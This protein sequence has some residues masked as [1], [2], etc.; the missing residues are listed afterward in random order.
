MVEDKK[1]EEVKDV[2]VTEETEAPQLAEEVA[3]GALMAVPQ[4][5]VSPNVLL[6]MA[7]TG[8][9]DIDK[10]GKL[11][12]LQERH[13]KNE[14]RKAYVVAMAAFK[15]NPPEIFKDK[16]VSY[17]TGKGTTTYDHA[18]LA[19][20]TGLINKGLSEHGLSAAWK[21]D[22]TEKSITVTCVITHV[23]GHSES[24][25]LTGPPDTSG[26]KN[27]IQAIA[28]TV[29]YLER[30]TILGLT[31]LSTYDM[32]DDGRGGK[33]SP[34]CNFEETEDIKCG[35]ADLGCVMEDEDYDYDEEEKN[36]LEK[37]G[38][39]S[40]SEMTKAQYEKGIKLIA[41]KK[42]FLEKK[43]ESK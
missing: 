7:L 40:V 2:A 25:S 28:S 42:E 33:D 22:Q 41:A 9:A 19:N 17:D 24:T 35:L 21:H 29:S 16:T 1:E 4:G 32:D 14:A 5:D 39:N 13:E 37:V 8:G 11:M 23:L 15:A 31:G 3:G 27:P 12:D 10:L 6:Q 26:G 36:F 38:A 43:R 18:T 30:Y 20:V 34:G